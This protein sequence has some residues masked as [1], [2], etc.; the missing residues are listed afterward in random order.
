MRKKSLL[1]MYII[2]FREII[3]KVKFN[4][5]SDFVYSKSLKFKMG[6]SYLLH[7]CAVRKPWN[8]VL[9]SVKSIKIS[10]LM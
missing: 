1:Y 9:R 4:Y 8:D 3:V 2:L 5:T 7:V 6:S 10:F